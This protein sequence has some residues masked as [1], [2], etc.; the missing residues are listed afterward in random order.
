VSAVPDDRPWSQHLLVETHGPWAGPSC[1]AFLRD[2]AG[3]LRAGRRTLVLLVQDGVLAAVPGRLGAL[4]DVLAA[5]GA[6]W[7]DRYSWVYRGLS[8]VDPVSGVTWAGM[9]EVAGHVLD[10]AVQVVWH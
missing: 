7:V 2:A 4:D 9:D 6:V 3:L 8:T 1:A 5:G 10:P